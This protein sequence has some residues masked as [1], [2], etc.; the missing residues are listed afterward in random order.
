MEAMDSGLVD[1]LE[2]RVRGSKNHDESNLGESRGI[3]SG[4]P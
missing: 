2:I 3:L 4:L 1:G